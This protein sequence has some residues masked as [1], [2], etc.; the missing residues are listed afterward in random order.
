MTSGDSLCH[1]VSECLKMG[2]GIAVLFKEKY[3]QVEYLKS[4]GVQTGGVAILDMTAS[5]GRYI[6][7]LVTKPKY[8]DKP[9]YETLT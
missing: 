8:F 6:Y 7:Y 4:Q 3:G 1:C 9:T 2:K 5:E